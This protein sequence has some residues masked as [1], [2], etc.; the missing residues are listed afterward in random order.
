MNSKEQLQAAKVIAISKVRSVHK[1]ETAMIAEKPPRWAKISKP[2]KHIMTIIQSDDDSSD[3]EFAGVAFEIES[4][5][6][7]DQKSVNAVAVPFKDQRQEAMPVTIFK[8]TPRVVKQH[9][10][11]RKSV[12][13]INK[14]SA[15]KNTCS[16]EPLKLQAC[17]LWMR[18]ESMAPMVQEITSYESDERAM[19]AVAQYVRDQAAHGN[20]EFTD[21]VICN[22][23]IYDRGYLLDILYAYDPEV[24]E[25]DSESYND[26][27][28]S[29][30]E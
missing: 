19:P 10:L 13:S 28:S 26:T 29:G 12:V 5:E 4:H 27:Y 24:H 8:T 16:S 15:G 18:A 23:L 3:L 14:I 22:G 9:Q 30:R 1:V 20:C 2:P 11:K 25:D 6:S 7:E 17:N 21:E